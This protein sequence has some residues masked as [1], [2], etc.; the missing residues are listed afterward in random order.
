MTLKPTW[1]MNADHALEH[2]L[3]RVRR[4]RTTSLAAAFA[5]SAVTID[6]SVSDDTPAARAAA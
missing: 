1:G 4:G 3:A 2:Y 6:G 5:R